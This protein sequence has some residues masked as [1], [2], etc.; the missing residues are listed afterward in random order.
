MFG[1]KVIHQFAPID[2]KPW[3]VRFLNHWSPNFVIWIESDIWPNTIKSIKE[4]QI[5]QVLLNLIEKL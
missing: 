4:K 1:N 5:K 3:I 2:H